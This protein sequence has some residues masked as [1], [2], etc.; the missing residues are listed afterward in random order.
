MSSEGALRRQRR[1]DKRTRKDPEM[2]DDFILELQLH[3]TKQ[4]RILEDA[5]APGYHHILDDP[6]NWQEWKV[7]AMKTL[8]DI[9]SKR[10]ANFAD[11]IEMLVE[12]AR[13]HGQINTKYLMRRVEEQRTVKFNQQNISLASYYREVHQ[14]YEI[15]ERGEI[16]QESISETDIESELFEETAASSAASTAGTVVTAHERR[17]AAPIEVD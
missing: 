6:Y 9:Y 14:P 2:P 11:E 16:K 17:I 15:N 1:M 12:Q 4:R 13:R 10:I 8:A 5:E 3:T 7:N